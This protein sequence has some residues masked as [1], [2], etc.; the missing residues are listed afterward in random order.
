MKA[1]F[2]FLP[3]LP[4]A[5]GIIA[6]ILLVEFTSAHFYVSVGVGCFLTFIALYAAG[7]HYLSFYFLSAVAGLCCSLAN[8]HFHITD[9]F[10]LPGVHQID[11]RIIECNINPDNPTIT[12][13][14]VTVDS[15]PT[16]PTRCLIYSIQLP[17]QTAL[18][19]E[20]SLKC[21][22]DRI[23]SHTDVPYEYD[24]TRSMVN[25]GISLIAYS[26][27]DI[28]EIKEAPPLFRIVNNVRNNI[29]NAI[30]NSPIN[31]NTASFLLA[32][33]IG[34][35]NYIDNDRISD[36]KSLG[37]AH[38][39]A[40][41]GLH[42]G[43]MAALFAFMIWPIRLLPHYRAI[44]VLLMLLAVWSYAL[45][46]GMGD[47]I[48]RAAIMLSVLSISS[49]LQRTYYPANAL[50]IA[51]SIILAAS[52]SSL[53]SPGFQL[54]VS[55]VLAIILFSPIVPKK[56]K[57]YPGLYF[58]ANM[59]V[60]PIA[61]MLG[62]G[63]ISAFHFATFASAFLPANII[64][65]LIFPFLLTG[66]VI[67]TIFT[68]IGVKL[69]FLGGILDYMLDY[70]DNSIDYVISICPS[71]IS[72]IHFSAWAFLPYIAALC[73]F[74]LAV[75]HRKHTPAITGVAFLVITFIIIDVTT[76][77]IPATELYVVRHPYTSIIIR[78]G[79]QTGILTTCHDYDTLVTR[80]I[81]L[82]RY[83]PFLQS[84]D[85]NELLNLSRHPYYVKGFAYKENRLYS[86]DYHIYILDNDTIDI[87][88]G[89]NPDYILVGQR[90]S[91]KLDSVV[92]MLAPDSIILGADIHPSRRKRF[93]REIKD[94]NIVIDL[95]QRPFSIVRAK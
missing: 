48:L 53:F 27:G 30:V 83:Q 40:L 38:I 69:T 72:A 77:S 49:L 74:A 39:L 67:I 94:H 84:R 22:I 87:I 28:S 24:P 45:I 34:E 57:R 41:S 60:I 61:A 70:M 9:G 43:L 10:S 78:S 32:V 23:T 54:S 92:S 76:P 66:G 11:A 59:L 58:L 91:G 20:I 12:V 64:V 2:S 88:P 56:L 16:L 17:S 81:A 25:D 52:P 6:G 14:L 37:V 15:V 89:T 71:Q 44:R 3:A 35:R 93:L 55:A 46:C 79:N 7:R 4:V 29:Y 82:S 80:Q 19:S 62:T 21:H 5:T 36:Y 8:S 50:L 42:V 65:G 73:L 51:I 63:M 47:S 90:F 18:Y 13:E 85:C 33:I 26:I 75:N 86:N 95:K 68:A 31:G 1:P